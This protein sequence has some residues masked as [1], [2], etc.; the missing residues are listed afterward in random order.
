MYSAIQNKC[1][2]IITKMSLDQTLGKACEP[3]FPLPF[4]YFQNISTNNTKLLF[5]NAVKFEK[6]GTYFF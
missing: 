4:Y 6:L 1:P 2:C 5:L 3:K